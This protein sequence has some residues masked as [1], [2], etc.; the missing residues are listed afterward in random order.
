MATKSK[1]K[2]AAETGPLDLDDLTDLYTRI[3]KQGD[4]NLADSLV[5]E[6]A[7]SEI[8][9]F[10]ADEAESHMSLSQLEATLPLVAEAVAL[11]AGS[12]K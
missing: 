3:L 10:L 12:K 6:A 7:T 5:L 4:K 9:D 1:A 11:R 8:A 2:A